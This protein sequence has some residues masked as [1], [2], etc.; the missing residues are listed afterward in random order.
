MVTCLT[1]WSSVVTT[2]SGKARPAPTAH[3][4]HGT[5]GTGGTGGSG[6]APVSANATPPESRQRAS[7]PLETDGS[8]GE[9]W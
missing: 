5:D 6:E 3:R 8:A 2:L 9:S 1:V 7:A 4:D